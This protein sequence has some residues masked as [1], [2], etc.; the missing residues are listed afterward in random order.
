[1]KCRISRQCGGCQYIQDDYADTLK[2]KYQTCQQLYKNF[3]AHVHPVVGMDHPYEYRNKVIV[4]FNSKYE[5][6][7]YEEQ[8][9]RIIPIQQC[10]L[11]DQETHHTLQQIQRLLKKYHVSI[12]DFKRNKGFLRHVLIRRAVQTHQTLVTLVVNGDM[13]RGSKNF[14][15]EL[16]KQC[17]TVKG[18]VLNINKRQT[19]VVLSK[20]EKVLYGKGFIVDELCGLTFKISSQSFYQINHEQCVK[21]YQKVID[22]CSLHKYDVVLDTYCG[23]GTIGMTIASHV[24]QVIGVEL[25]KE[26]YKDAL[27]NAKMNHIDNIYFYNQDATE[28]MQ[29]VS[30]ENKRIDCVIL[31]PPR[32]GTTKEFIKAIQFLKPQSVIYVSC[33]PHTQVRDLKEFQKIGYDFEDVY[34]Y[35]MFPFT[36]HVE[37]V[38]L[39]SKVKG[40]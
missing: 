10:P 38:V 26:A 36:E 15:N 22:L 1:M 32:A 29:T 27:N 4:A 19:S 34:L 39:M 11:H 6:G 7:L 18:I 23:I 24:Q 9:H 13:M 12:Y 14:C 25:N 5:Y 2:K 16:V 20:N 30:S 40:R 35:D 31:D 8:S 33:D 37:T 21:L 17:P 28:F 3:D